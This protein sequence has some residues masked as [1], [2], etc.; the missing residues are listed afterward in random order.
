VDLQRALAFGFR[1]N[2]VH[3]LTRV[4]KDTPQEVISILWLDFD[5]LPG[6]QEDLAPWNVGGAVFGTTRNDYVFY[7]NSV[8]VPPTRRNLDPEEALATELDLRAKSYALTSFLQKHVEGFETA[9]ITSFAPI[10]GVRNSRIVQCEYETSFDDIRQERG[11]PDEIGRYAWTDIHKAEFQPRHGGGYGVPYRAIIPLRVEHLLVAG[12]LITT[13]IK[14][15]Q[16]TR[17]TVHAM[18]QGEAAGTAAALAVQQGA[19]PRRLDVRLLQDT[20]LKNGVILNKES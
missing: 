20:L 12:R 13:E 16:S 3:R 1:N 17:N 9:L 7:V 10:L 6:W 2:C 8:N 19:T 14:A 5:R 15:H 18:M 4:N 11:F